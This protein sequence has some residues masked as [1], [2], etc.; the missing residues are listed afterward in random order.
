MLRLPESPT[1]GYI[2]EYPY[3]NTH[4]PSTHFIMC[5]T[6]TS[7][8][9][10]ARVLRAKSSGQRGTAKCGITKNTHTMRVQSQKMFLVSNRFFSLECHYA[11]GFMLA[12]GA[13]TGYSM[14]KTIG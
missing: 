1:T 7:V 11:T 3:T 13:A 2:A 12:M 8:H 4:N 14:T 6:G 5:T 9:E 10:S